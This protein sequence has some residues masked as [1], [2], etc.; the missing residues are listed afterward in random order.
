MDR[1]GPS[2]QETLDEMEKTREWLA[3]LF[4]AREERNEKLKVP[5]RQLES[6][7]DLY[8][9]RK[10]GLYKL[11]TRARMKATGTE[12]VVYRSVETGETWVRPATEFDERFSKEGGAP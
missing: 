7:T 11:V 9:H 5:L 8:R 4:G 6:P 10:G 3:P 12:V 1:R 2:V